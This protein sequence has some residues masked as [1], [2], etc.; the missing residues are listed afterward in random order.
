MIPYLARALAKEDY[1]SYGQVLMV[2]GVLTVLFTIGLP[3]LIHQGLANEDESIQNQNFI[4]SVANMLLF[5]VLGTLLIYFLSEP[6]ANYFKNAALGSM[7]RIY[8]F[9]LVFTSLTQLF[10]S[11][12]NFYKKVKQ[13]SSANILSN[14]IR[15]ALLFCSIQFFDRLDMIAYA[16][17]LSAILGTILN[18]IY[19]PLKMFKAKLDSKTM[20]H[21]IFTGVPLGL[22]GI[23]T[24]LIVQTDGIMISRLLPTED[25]AYYRMGAIPIPFFLLIYSSIVTIT[26]PEVNRFFSK[27]EFKSIINLKRKSSLTI[28]F[29]AYPSII[30]L[31]CF[32]EEFVS[33]FFGE[34][35]LPSRFVFLIYNFVL[36]LRI[37]DYRDVLIASGKTTFILFNDLIFFVLNLVLNYLLIQHFGIEGAAIASTVIFFLIALVLQFRTSKVLGVRTFHFFNLSKLFK[38]FGLSLMLSF[39]CVLIH[40]FFDSLLSLIVLGVFYL[41]VI[42]LLLLRFKV[43]DKKEILSYTKNLKIFASLNSFLRKI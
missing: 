36:F 24:F 4:A 37:I 41:L 22:A 19:L 17:L 28:A 1:A 2:F 16:L 10:S 7:L 27:G 43:V 12:L 3:K 6:V 29:L 26:L 14:L 13:L 35:Y 8:S 9:S 40:G 32:F 20:R 15:V 30:F 25:Y 31:L 34:S 11:I 23:V 33:Y 42:Y 5:G 21:Q 38:I 18:L 39:S